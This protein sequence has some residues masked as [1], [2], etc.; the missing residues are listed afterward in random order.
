LPGDTVDPAQL[1]HVPIAAVPLIHKTKALFPHTAFLPGHGFSEAMFSE[2]CLRCARH[3]VYSMCPVRTV[4][5]ARS[6]ACRVESHLDLCGGTDDRLLSSVKFANA[7]KHD[8]PQKP[9]VCPTSFSRVDRHAG[10][11]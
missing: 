10:E 7:S 6:P 5:D 1:G 3:D 11:P 2:K 4:R 9:M 8:R